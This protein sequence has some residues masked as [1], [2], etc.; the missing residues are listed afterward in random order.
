MKTPAQLR[1]N[2]SAK[3]RAVKRRSHLIGADRRYRLSDK[4]HISRVL[5]HSRR[6]AKRLGYV[7]I[8][9]ATM[10]AYP[11]DKKCERCGKFPKTT[12]LCADHDHETG[13]FR[14]W[15]CHKCNRRQP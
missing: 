3:G 14:G 7:A 5:Q 1:Y 15:I 10:W 13:E 9:S 8:D 6:K 2:S 11:S 4:G 12:R